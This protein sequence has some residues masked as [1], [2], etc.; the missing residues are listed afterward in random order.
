MVF[1]D[2]AASL[3][4]NHEY[5]GRLGARSAAMAQHSAVKPCKH[6]GHT[7]AAPWQPPSA[8]RPDVAG[9]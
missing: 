5:A 6:T 9:P 3:V 4:F 8:V 1:P 2:C 7:T